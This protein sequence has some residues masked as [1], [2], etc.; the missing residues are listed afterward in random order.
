[1]RKLLLLFLIAASTTVSAQFYGGLSTGYALGAAERANGL[2]IN[3]I[4]TQSNIYGSYGQGFNF[5]LKLGYMFSDVVGFELGTSYLIGASQTK[6][7]GKEVGKG[8]AEAK[9]SGLRLAPQLVLKSGTGLYS[10]VGLIVP[11]AG[12]T[13]VTFDSMPEEIP[14]T[15]GMMGTKSGTQEFRGSFS[16]GV[17][18]A[19]G[20][21]YALSDKVDLFAEVEYIGLSIK[22]GTAELTEFSLKMADGKEVATLKDLP[23]SKIHTE[24]VDE[25][26]MSDN[27][28][29][30]KATK[31]LRQE[32]PFSS[33][34]LNIG[35]SFKF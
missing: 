33:I 4:G 7:D 30:N 35:V 26:K 8:F 18:G 32:A 23:Y 12:K 19:I 6:L 16:V 34:G 31:E 20:Y 25:V 21:S 27:Q 10:R 9:S 28:D 13:T 3:S 24:F 29:P 22:S 15:G 1:M 2:E 11:V 17:I 5:N 14:G